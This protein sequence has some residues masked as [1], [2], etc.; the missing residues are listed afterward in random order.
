MNE[1][2]TLSYFANQDWHSFSV[3]TATDFHDIYEIFKQPEVHDV[4][5]NLVETDS[6]EVLKIAVSTDGIPFALRKDG[7]LRQ[8]SEFECR[9][10]T[11]LYTH[12]RNKNVKP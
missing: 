11:A 7:A 4:G 6:G 3:Y 12:V 10:D 2:L 8:L 5:K 1:T 9:L